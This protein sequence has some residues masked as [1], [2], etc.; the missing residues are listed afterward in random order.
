MAA[1]ADRKTRIRLG[2]W[3]A[4]AAVTLGLGLVGPA[5]RA[6]ADQVRVD[7]GAAPRDLIAPNALIGNWLTVVRYKDRPQ[8]VR[9]ELHTVEPGKTAG[10]L[11]YSSPKRCFVDLEYG[12]PDRDRHIFYIVPF[13]NCF[14]YRKTDYISITGIEPETPVFSDLSAQGQGY[15]QVPKDQRAS[16]DTAASDADPLDSPAPIGGDL[17]QQMEYVITLGDQSLESGILTR[18]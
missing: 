18:Q 5:G 10:R 9:L 8:P 14:R 15:R 12:G 13:T 4:L 2:I 17:A 6:A 7:L 16:A 1:P 11:I 3:A